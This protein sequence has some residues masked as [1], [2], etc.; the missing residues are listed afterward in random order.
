VTRALADFGGPKEHGA[1]FSNRFADRNAFH[2]L[3]EVGELIDR[4]VLAIG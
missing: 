2:S 3:A 1:Q 4:L